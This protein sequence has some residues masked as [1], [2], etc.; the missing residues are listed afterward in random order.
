M[1]PT[2]SH[3]PSLTCKLKVEVCLMFGCA[4]CHTGLVGNL[5]CQLMRARRICVA[6]PDADCKYTFAA[7]CLLNP[8]VE[9]RTLVLGWARV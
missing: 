8:A 1:V 6:M 5:A 7:S 2:E 9:V 4:S 3:V